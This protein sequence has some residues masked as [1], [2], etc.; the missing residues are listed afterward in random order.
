MCAVPCAALG[1]IRTLFAELPK[2]EGVLLSS[3]QNP[4]FCDTQHATTS[5]ITCRYVRALNAT[6]KWAVI[7]GK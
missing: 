2:C 5:T 1:P 7:T 3:G 4:L 6:A